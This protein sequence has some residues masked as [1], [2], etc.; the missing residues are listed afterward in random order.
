MDRRLEFLKLVFSSITGKTHSVEVGQDCVEEALTEGVYFDGSSVKGYASVNSSDLLLKPA[1]HNITPLPWSTNVAVVPCSVYDA[2]G[3]LHSHDP[4]GILGDVAEKARANDMRLIAGSELEFFLVRRLHDRSI[5]PADLGGYFATT[6]S[7]GALALRRKAFRALKTMG[8]AATTHHH[9]VAPGQHEIGLRHSE[10]TTAGDQVMLSKMTIAELAANDGLI[11]TFMPKPFPRVN[12]SGM[13]IHLSLWDS[14]GERNLFADGPRKISQIAECFI[15][16]LLKHAPSLAAI[17]A[18]TVNSFKRLRPG[19]EAPTR[20]AWGPLNRTTMIRV[21]LYNGSKAKA[22]IELR[23]P[24]PSCSP[25]LALAAI[26][27]AGLD[28]VEK[29]LIPPSPTKE[30]VFKSTREIESLP[31][32]LDDALKALSKDSVLLSALGTSLVRTYIDLR[33]SEWSEYA[34]LHDEE[35]SSEITEWELSRYLYVN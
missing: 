30:D 9:E 14:V 24:D 20:I 25:H 17:V 19:Y 32:T 11:A 21:P 22:R 28:G 35:S 34:E 23:C 7:D 2:S 29:V 8:I 3:E 13:H 1:S 10:A 26:L 31:E 12:G 16:G 33:R 18:P 5:E 6:P 15:A 27:A 4:R